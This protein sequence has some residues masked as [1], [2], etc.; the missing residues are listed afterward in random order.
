MKASNLIS[1]SI[2]AGVY[3]ARL[4]RKW[5]NNY[6]KTRTIPT[7][8]RGQH[9]KVKSILGDEDVKMKI[10]GYLRSSKYEVTP[11]R[12]KNFIEREVLPWNRI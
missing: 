1:E 4:I 6:I 11:K 10:M 2:G 3:T 8:K 7:S 9:Q 12:L 5:A